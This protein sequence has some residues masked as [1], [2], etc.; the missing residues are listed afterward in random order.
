LTAH[1]KYKWSF[2]T[3]DGDMDVKIK[4]MNLDLEFDASTQ[5]G[6]PASELAPKVSV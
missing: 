4:K 3:V 6:T 5:P 2:I 1:F